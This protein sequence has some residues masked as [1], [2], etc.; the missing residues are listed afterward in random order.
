MAS[1]AVNSKD[2]TTCI[3]DLYLQNSVQAKG[4]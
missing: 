1:I 4:S 3:S 2:S